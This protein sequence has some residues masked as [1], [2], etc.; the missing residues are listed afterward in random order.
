MKYCGMR[1]RLLIQYRGIGQRSATT[2]T[3]WLRVDKKQR[4]W[5]AQDRL[6]GLPFIRP[7]VE[8]KRRTEADK[9]RDHIKWM[10]RGRR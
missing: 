2:Q 7:S 6:V 10:E 4:K 5:H 9:L 3:C 1:R 8:R